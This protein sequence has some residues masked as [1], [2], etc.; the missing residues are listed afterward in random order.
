MPSPR[1]RRR[2]DPR[3]R[4][5]ARRLIH[6]LLPDL[7]LARDG[8]DDERHAFAQLLAAAPAVT[9][10]WMT[11]DDDGKPLS[12]SPLVERL[13]Q[14][15]GTLPGE[16]CGEGRETET[17]GGGPALAPRPAPALYPARL[18]PTACEPAARTSAAD[19]PRPADE[20]AVLAGLHGSRQQLGE[21]LPL[22]VR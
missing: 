6:R 4:D 17:Q 1:C 8:F 10:S 15:A 7:P 9:L 2:E 21:V 3:F 20:H 22:A 14:T 12:P 13:L 19:D 5:A 18:P 16:P 11:A